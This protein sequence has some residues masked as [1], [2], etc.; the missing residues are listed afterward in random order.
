MSD[1]AVDSVPRSIQPGDIRKSTIAGTWYPGE[2]A[3]LRAMIE[4]FLDTVAPSS[5]DGER[6]S[7]RAPG[8][9]PGW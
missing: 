3:Q 2:P 1:G 4:G 5:M 7:A 6:I 9:S 8:R